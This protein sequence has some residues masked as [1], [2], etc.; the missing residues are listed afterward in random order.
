RVGLGQPLLGLEERQRIRERL[1]IRDVVVTVDAGGDEV[2]WRLGA[3]TG[4]AAV[5]VDDELDGHRVRLLEGVA[6]DLAV[7]LD[8]VRVA[9]EELSPG[10]EDGQIEA[11]ALAQVVAVHVAAERAGWRGADDAD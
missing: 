6:G 9:G 7:A 11:G 10:P 4:E 2:R 8:L 5:L 3:R 1:L